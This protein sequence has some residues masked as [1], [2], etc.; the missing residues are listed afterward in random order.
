MRLVKPIW[1]CFWPGVLL[2]VLAGI[3][4]TWVAFATPGGGITVDEA[5]FPKPSPI[6]FGPLQ[7]LQQPWNS[8]QRADW[9]VAETLASISEIAYLPPVDADPAYR[10]LG[11]TNVMPI[12]ANSM[13]G[14]V[15]SADDVV[16]IAFRGTDSGEVS[17]WMT[18]LGRSAVE[19]P[20][21]PIHKGFHDAYISLQS[22]ILTALGAKSPKHIWVTGHSLGGALALVCAFELIESQQMQIDGLITFGQPMVTRKKLADHIDIILQGRY[23]H[24]VNSAD[25]VPRVPPSYEHCGSLVWFTG[26][27]V[28]RSPPKIRV[29]GAVGAPP[30]PE[31]PVEEIDEVVPVTDDEFEA[32]KAQMKVSEAPLPPPAATNEPRVYGASSPM[33]D[34]HSMTIYLE[35]VR[36]LL[37]L[38]ESTR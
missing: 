11:F 34:D 23:A 22:Q 7:R 32:L 15:L 6:V 26:T 10:Q 5:S 21:G 24:F 37:G 31:V 27:F 19:T 17:D 28:K 1:K 38:T 14:Y 13:I 35:K 18:N 33:I 16:V 25:I 29:F 9:P 4:A 8:E 36:K 20:H 2:L 12:V 30:N 3:G